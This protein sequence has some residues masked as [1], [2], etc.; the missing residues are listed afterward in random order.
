MLPSLPI[1][2]GCFRSDTTYRNKGLFTF[3][4]IMHVKNSILEKVTTWF[5]FNLMVHVPSE[6]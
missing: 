6:D 3:A 4:E 2:I 5:V 1:N